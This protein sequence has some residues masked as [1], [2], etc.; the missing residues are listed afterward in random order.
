MEDENEG[1]YS[2]NNKYNDGLNM[3]AGDIHH[4]FEDNNGSK[5]VRTFGAQRNQHERARRFTDLT[6]LFD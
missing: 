4:L 5:K 2:Y 1:R 6:D 3:E